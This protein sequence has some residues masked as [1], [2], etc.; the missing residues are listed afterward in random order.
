[1][2]FVYV[3]RLLRGYLSEIGRGSLSQSHLLESHASHLTVID[4]PACTVQSPNT[5][6]VNFAFLISKNI[7]AGGTRTPLGV[8]K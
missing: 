7:L 5:V 3:R 4:V 6:D 8:L 2:A 1:M